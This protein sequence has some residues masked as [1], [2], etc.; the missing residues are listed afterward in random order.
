MLG[1]ALEE[2]ALLVGALLEA[3][4]SVSLFIWY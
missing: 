2:A 4:F 1:A 3:G